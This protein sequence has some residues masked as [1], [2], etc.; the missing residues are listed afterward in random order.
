[1]EKHTCPV[2]NGTGRQAANADQKRYASVIAGYDTTNDT[3]KCGNCGG[4]Y[5]FGSPSGQVKLNKSGTACTHSY[6]SSNN[7]RCLT[8]YIC[9]HCDD[10]YQI[11]SG[12]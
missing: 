4:Q 3:I 5:M 12:D 8:T 2:C 11:D 7:G 10:Q 9:Q 6:V 1:M